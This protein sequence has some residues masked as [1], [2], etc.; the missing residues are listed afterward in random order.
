[1]RTR[2]PTSERGARRHRLGLTLRQEPGVG[3]TVMAYRDRTMPE[4]DDL[5]GVRVAGH[6]RRVVVIPAMCGRC[7][8]RRYQSGALL[9]GVLAHVPSS[10]HRPLSRSTFR[11]G[12]HIPPDVPV[13]RTERSMS[14]QLLDRH[15]THRAT[16][17]VRQSNGRA[18]GARKAHA[19]ALGQLAYGIEHVD[20][21]HLPWFD[22]DTSWLGATYSGPMGSTP[23]G[24]QPGYSLRTTSTE[25][26]T[27]GTSPRFSSQWRVFRSSGQPTPGP[28]SVV[29]PS[30][31]SVIVPCST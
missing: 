18:P 14:I 20:L 5:D 11:A 27:A 30:R 13:Q 3:L 21:V 6:G 28:Y 9:G 1:M 16:S 17:Q 25:I 23:N 8:A 24:K 19:G 26:S 7:R 2:R 31:W 10:C 22:D 29:T 4:M 15:G 12:R